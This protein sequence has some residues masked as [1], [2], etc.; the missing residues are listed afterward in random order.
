MG[1]G[2]DPLGSSALRRC[3]T[4]VA[5]CTSYI[6][7]LLRATAFW[8]TILLPLVI[9]GGL[10]TD[11]ATSDPTQLALLVGLNVLCILFGRSYRPGDRE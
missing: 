3:A 9:V 4:G 1:L 11:T 7:E 2:L 6:V 8:G 5:T 10:L